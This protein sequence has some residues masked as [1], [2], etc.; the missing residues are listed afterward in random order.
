MFCRSP[1]KGKG[2]NGSN[3]TWQVHPLSTIEKPEFRVSWTPAFM[4][5]SPSNETQLC[6]GQATKEDAVTIWQ[7]WGKGYCRHG[8]RRSVEGLEVTM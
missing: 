4:N 2:A 3:D 7:A 8:P 1:R 5:F 6:T